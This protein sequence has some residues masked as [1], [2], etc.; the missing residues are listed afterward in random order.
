[1]RPRYAPRSKGDIGG[2]QKAA[3][4]DVEPDHRHVSATAQ[5]AI[6]GFRILDHVRFANEVVAIPLLREGAAHEHDARL[7]HRFRVEC[8]RGVDVGERPGGENREVGAES[9]GGV[10]DH[11]RTGGGLRAALLWEFEFLGSG[12]VRRPAGNREFWHGGQ[13]GVRLAHLVTSYRD[14]SAA[15][16]E[17]ANLWR[18]ECDESIRITGERLAGRSRREVG[19]VAVA[20]LDADTSQ[21]I[22]AVESRAAGVGD[23]IRCP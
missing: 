12:D 22:V 1:M 15:L 19:I 16:G 2:T 11:A 10:D 7:P 17:V 9:A 18:G 6:C 14:R 23:E 21:T 13:I 8:E 3:V 20:G 4:G 5:H